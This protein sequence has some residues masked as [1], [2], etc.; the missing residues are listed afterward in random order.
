LEKNRLKSLFFEILFAVYHIA[1]GVVAGSYLY[2]GIKNF[3]EEDAQKYCI[4]K[5]P[6][7][8]YHFLIDGKTPCEIDLGVAAFNIVGMTILILIYWLIANIPVFA[9]KY[10]LKKRATKIL[11]QRG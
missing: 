1:T 9:S 10:I 8:F 6:G 11:S 5:Q 2:Y 7:E 3:F 4:Y